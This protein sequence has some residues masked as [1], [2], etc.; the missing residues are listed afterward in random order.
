MRQRD[1]LDTGREG[2]ATNPPWVGLSLAG[3][4]GLGGELAC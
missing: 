1:G 2:W 3:G 4:P